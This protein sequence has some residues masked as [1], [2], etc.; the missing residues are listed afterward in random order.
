MFGERA[1]RPPRVGG[2]K[3]AACTVAPSGERSA[4]I[5]APGGNTGALSGGAG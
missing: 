1:V 5:V 3:N 2:G 4:H